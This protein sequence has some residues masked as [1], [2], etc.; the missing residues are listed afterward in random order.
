MS[1][2]RQTQ[3][4]LLRTSKQPP[5]W[6]VIELRPQQTEEEIA[7]T[8]I[9]E[10]EAWVREAHDSVHRAIQE[11]EQ[12]RTQLTELCASSTPK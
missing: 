6:K 2:L 3:R 1:V 11:L 12:M 4:S 9:A 8:I 5:S 7:R 10:Q